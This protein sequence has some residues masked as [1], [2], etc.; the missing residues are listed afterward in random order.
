MVSL[1]RNRVPIGSGFFVL[2][3][4]PPFEMFFV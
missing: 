1:K 4:V 2:M 3:N